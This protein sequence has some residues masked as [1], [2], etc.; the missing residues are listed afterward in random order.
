MKNTVI[1]L[2]FFISTQVF[3]TK[4]L[5]KNLGIHGH[6]FKIIE[7]SL[8]DEIYKRLKKTDLNKLNQIQKKKILQY[9]DSPS[10]EKNFIE[11]R[12][13]KVF[14]HDPSFSFDKSIYSPSG[15][16]IYL[17]GTP[18]NPLLQVQL[19]EPLI[20]IDGNIEKQVKYALKHKSGK[21]ILVSG[22]PL[23]IQRK[24]KRWIYFDQ[25][26]YLT[27]KL[28]I[29]EV[30]AIVSQEDSRLKITLGYL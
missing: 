29:S 19:K 24:H 9:I 11:A 10:S 20:F 22:S 30:P 15:E 18:I 17:Q 5:A 2:L 12:N 21:I 1:I 13:I 8:L 3:V 7:V 16:L 28:N 14:Y 27:T 23:K 26:N 6:V 4:A 25:K